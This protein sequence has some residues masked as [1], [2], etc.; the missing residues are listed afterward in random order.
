METDPG[1][2]TSITT[3][4]S[5]QTDG[6]KSLPTGSSKLVGNGSFGFIWQL[7]SDRVLKVPKIQ[8]EGETHSDYYNFINRSEIQNEKAVYER[9][10]GHDGIIQCFN[11]QNDTLELAF[12][13]QGDLEDYIREKPI[14]SRQFRAGWIRSLVETFNYVHFRRVVVVDIGLRNIL[15]QQDSLKL[16][17]F[18]ESCILPLDEDMSQFNANGISSRIEILHLGFIL[19]SIAAWQEF[20]YE[21]FEEEG[22]PEATEL[23]KT[24]E[25]LF[26]RIIQKCWNGDYGSMEAL[27][28][29]IRS[30]KDE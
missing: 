21:Y 5:T 15:V 20:K 26:A 7:T 12:A 24:D 6:S 8:G 27:Q 28:E 19:Y 23:P 2:P 30:T 10:G 29:D 22:W 25:V 11:A 14:P 13:E 1:Q 3:P 9:L 4:P 18:G 17:D 16:C